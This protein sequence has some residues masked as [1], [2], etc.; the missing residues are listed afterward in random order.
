[1]EVPI[2]PFNSDVYNDVK[3]KKQI[4]NA[5]NDREQANTYGVSLI[6]YHTHNGTDSPLLSLNGGLNSIAGGNT[7]DVQFNDN[8]SLAG[9]PT[10]TFNSSTNV[11]S[12]GVESGSASIVGPTA[13]LP[14]GFGGSL[15]ISSGDGFTS[16]DGGSLILS[17][18]QGG[19]TGDGGLLNLAAG[20]GGATSGGGGAV[21]ITGGNPGGS[22]TLTGGTSANVIIN[23][24]DVGGYLLL[25][26]GGNAGGLGADVQ[27]TAGSGGT[28]SSTHGGNI[29]LIGGAG[30]AHSSVGGDINLTPGA[31]AAGGIAGIINFV[32]GSSAAIAQIKT[33]LM[34]AGLTKSYSLPNFAGQFKVTGADIMTYAGT[35]TLDTTLAD[36]HV[37]TTAT[38]NS[39]INAST[40]GVAGQVIRILIINDVVTGKTITFGTNFLPSGTLVGTA[41]KAAT[42]EFVSDGNNFYEV[43]RTLGL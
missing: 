5:L 39:T 25:N 9:S 15:N 17:T 16:G 6:P 28:A 34:S 20:D 37:T 24:G 36:L 30:L 38:V 35:I 14:A 21:L 3:A 1:M 23:A 33:N 12:L 31:P 22:I 40:R 8:G 4:D 13:I 11:L 19:A 32:D 10:F 41:S 29:N 18:G 7:T 2:I 27:I 42:I 26:A 43:A